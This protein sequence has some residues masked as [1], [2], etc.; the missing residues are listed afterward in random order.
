[1]TDPESFEDL[2]SEVE[3]SD[4]FWIELAKIEFTEELS[5]W[6]EIKNVTRAD[7]ARALASSQPYITKVLRG[8]A[9]FTMA[10]IVKLSRALGLRLRLHLAP[11]E[12]NTV[13]RAWDVLSGGQA[14]LEIPGT[15]TR[16]VAADA[17][18]SETAGA[19]V[20]L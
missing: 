6:M 16:D 14:S 15:I 19:V 3:R 11:E 5:R 12:S 9:N 10:S 17:N 2:Y 20:N 18:S 7:L 1:M 8:N 4:E 13:W